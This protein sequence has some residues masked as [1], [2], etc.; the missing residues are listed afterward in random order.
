MPVG[1]SKWQIMMSSLPRD[2]S[3]G[4]YAPWGWYK[5]RGVLSNFSQTI[6]GMEIIQDRYTLA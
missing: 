5:W 1:I 2:R 3:F 6:V 4:F